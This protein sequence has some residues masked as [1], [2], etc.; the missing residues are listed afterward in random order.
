MLSGP[1][2]H[3][4]HLVSKERLPFSAAYI[5]T[6]VLTLYFSIVVRPHTS[7]LLLPISDI[8]S[9]R[10]SYLGSLVFAIAQILALISYIAAYFP[11]GWQTLRFGGQMAFR[12]AGAVLPF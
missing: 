2:N 8:T 3:L 7:V 11:G 5:G 4:K 6:L 12:G 1:I 9:Q 10:K